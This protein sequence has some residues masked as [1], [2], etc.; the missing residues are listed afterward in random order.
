MLAGFAPEFQ[1]A[2]AYILGGL[3]WV[4]ILLTFTALE[5]T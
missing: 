2:R 3:S 5:D 4:S 1:N